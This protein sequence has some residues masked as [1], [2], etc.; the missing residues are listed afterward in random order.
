MYEKSYR[1]NSAIFLIGILFFIFGFITW[2]NSQLIPYLKI[3]CELTNTQSY[4]VAT[5]FFAAYFFMA[6]PSSWVLKKIGFKNGMSLG[7]FVM[8]VGALLFLPAAQIRNYALFLIGLFIIGTGLALLQ[9]ASN[10]YVII[11][12]PIE[13]AAKRISIMGVCNK[14]AGIIAVYVLGS[15][16]LSNVDELKARL[17]TLPPD[18]K[19]DVLDALAQKVVIPYLIIALV[20]SVLG[21][22]FAKLHLKE[23]KEEE[24]ERMEY[25]RG[26]IWQ[27]PHLVLGAIAIFFYVGAEVISY[28][29]FSSFGETL[30]YPLSS[31]KGFATFTGYGLLLG[32]LVSIA[33]IP[34]YISQRKALQFASMLSMVLVSLAMTMK[35]ETAVACFALLGFSNSVMWPAIWPLAIGGLGRHTKMGSAFLIMG[36]VGGALLPPFY[37]YVADM[38]HSR[39]LAYGILL[40]CYLVILYYAI[41]GY[42]AGL[43]KNNHVR[44]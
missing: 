25:S 44:S 43:K 31:S 33:I 38:I 39:Q 6:I 15:I 2:A 17:L 28:D 3:A 35:G 29:T 26:S 21:L 12:G 18:M 24:A 10:P 13:S 34:K 40:P 4:F 19:A 27:Y 36:I 41:S 16:T 11:L 9:T 42:K 37:G 5:A 7:L 30:G 20:L 22:I 14:V 32:Y 1:S 8:S 23:I